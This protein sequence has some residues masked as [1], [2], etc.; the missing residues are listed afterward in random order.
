MEGSVSHLYAGY[1]DQI[2][3][4]PSVAREMVEWVNSQVGYSAGLVVSDPIDS[5]SGKVRYRLSNRVNRAMSRGTGAETYRYFNR[6]NLDKKTA[7]ELISSQIVH[8]HQHE[9]LSSLRPKFGGQIVMQFHSAFGLTG[10]CVL[11]GDCSFLLSGCNECPVAR[12]MFAKLPSRKLRRITDQYLCANTHYVFNSHWTKL[13]AEKSGIFGI[14]MD[15]P[16]IYPATDPAIFNPGKL[17]EHG[18]KR[19]GF[20]AFSI[21]SSNKGFQDYI[22]IL[23][24]LA[25]KQPVE[26]VVVG[27]H[28]GIRPVVDGVE[29]EYL[30]AVLQP[31]DVASALRTMDLLIIP[32]GSESFGRVS[33]EAQ[34]CGVPVVAHRVGG[35]PETVIEGKSG[36]LI[37]RGDIAS[38][39]GAADYILSNRVKYCNPVDS[40]HRNFLDQ[41]SL[42]S[43]GRSLLELYD[44]ILSNK[45]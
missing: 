10:G 21:H 16:I 13:V 43:C 39:I 6:F 7:S 23:K 28:N 38:A 34:Y 29:I 11:N 3:G 44:S 36:H 31:S 18:V 41:F 33:I 26:G 40:V 19:I 12:S 5:F 14:D 20:L 42:D 17:A 25:S 22:A 1:L 45:R 37:D 35:L 2:G 9:L 24:G 15:L 27:D 4:I 32:S 8:L 30:G